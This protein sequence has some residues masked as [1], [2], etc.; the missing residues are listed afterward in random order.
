[1]YEAFIMSIIGTK[2]TSTICAHEAVEEILKS[3]A[4]ESYD[5][6]DDN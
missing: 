4:E 5:D 6:D 1:M 2:R 3:V